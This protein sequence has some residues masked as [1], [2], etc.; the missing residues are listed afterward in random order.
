MEEMRKQMEEEMRKQMEEEMKKKIE[1]ERKKMEEEMKKKIEKERK[2]MEEEM[3]KK[4]EKNRKKYSL[5]PIKQITLE[6]CKKE[7]KRLRKTRPEQYKLARKILYA[8]CY[9]RDHH[10]LKAPP[11]SGKREIWEIINLKWWEICHNPNKKS[12]W[13]KFGLTPDDYVPFLH[14]TGL[15]RISCESQLKEHRHLGCYSE[16]CSKRQETIDSLEE[17]RKLIGNK[18]GFI[19]LDEADYASGNRMTCDE[20]INEWKGPLLAISATTEEVEAGW[21]QRKLDYLPHS[22]IPPK[23]FRGKPWF[24]DNNLVFEPE[25]FIEHT[26]PPPPEY[27]TFSEEEKNKW[28]EENTEKKYAFTEQA[29]EILKDCKDSIDTY[30]EEPDDF[31]HHK[32]RNVI[33]V[34]IKG[35][36]GTHRDFKSFMK[37]KI[38]LEAVRGLMEVNV[39]HSTL[40]FYVKWADSVDD[41]FKFDSVNHWY[42]L[43]KGHPVIIFICAKASR[44]TEFAQ[45]KIDESGIINKQGAHFRIFAKHDERKIDTTSNYNTVAQALGRANHFDKIGHPIRLYACK[46]TCEVEAGRRDPPLR[47]TSVRVRG[48]SNSSSSEEDS[49]SDEFANKI[50]PTR[51]SAYA[52]RNNNN[53]N[54]TNN[55]THRYLIYDNIEI[56]EKAVTELEYTFRKPKKDENGFYITA[57]NKKSC[58]VTLEETLNRGL[59]GAYGTNNGKKTLRRFIPCYVD[60]QDKTTERFVVI[61]NDC[62]D[63]KVN[64]CIEK[65]KPLLKSL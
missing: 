36:N 10:I 24:L 9:K 2:K 28:D 38:E 11:K 41:Y 63:E 23:T 27:K 1:K 19:G 4:I 20:I 49:D 32:N 48:R 56:T 26:N 44:S 37:N 6:M 57:L 5:N 42:E 31:N 45:P 34:R 59:Q 65:Y 53:N 51:N 52:P 46:W 47:R 35:H 8:Y 61:V 12:P 60:T 13:Y 55:K 14:I 29:K 54:N 25:P 64:K 30:D 7:L 33:V 62:S 43:P 15:K 22:L 3:K 18:R 50:I 16:A 40:K 17:Y 21:K 39:G 58:R